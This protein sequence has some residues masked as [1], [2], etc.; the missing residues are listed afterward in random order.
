MGRRVPVRLRH[1][2]ATRP[3]GWEGLGHESKRRT[4]VCMRC[5]HE[6]WAGALTHEAE[7]RLASCFG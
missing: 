2:L 4:A 7:R 3:S 1:S 6:A 5:H